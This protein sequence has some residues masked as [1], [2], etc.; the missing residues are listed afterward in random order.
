MTLDTDVRESLVSEA[1]YRQSIHP[2]REILERTSELGSMMPE[3]VFASLVRT[4]ISETRAHTILGMMDVAKR[5][6]WKNVSSSTRAVYE[7][8]RALKEAGIKLSDLSDLRLPQPG[9]STESRPEYG[10][11]T[12]LDRVLA[13]GLTPERAV[14]VMGALAIL[15]EE[16]MDGLRELHPRTRNNLLRDL[17]RTGLDWR[18]PGA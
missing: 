8:K 13:S 11:K 14:Q 18:P 2:A 16:G 9:R 17:A 10:S 12:D 15:R 5:L 6:G 1:L 4:G 3:E 7:A